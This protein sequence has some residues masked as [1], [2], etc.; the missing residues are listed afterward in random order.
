[1][2]I[3]IPYL[4]VI[5]GLIVLGTPV[6]IY[7]YTFWLSIKLFLIPAFKLYFDLY[8]IGGT[9]GIWAALFAVSF[10]CSFWFFGLLAKS[11]PSTFQPT[12]KE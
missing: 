4:D 10:I 3:K 5:V 7:L 9:F 8:G 2:R 1:M 11:K 6:V 12:F